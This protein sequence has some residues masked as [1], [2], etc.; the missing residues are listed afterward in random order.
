[1]TL[2]KSEY[3]LDIEKRAELAA[4]LVQYNHYED[5][6]LWINCVSNSGEIEDH[7]T[8]SHFAIR[9]FKPKK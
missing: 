5:L 7:N 6:T 4:S 3:I 8:I 2:K 1:M 9:N